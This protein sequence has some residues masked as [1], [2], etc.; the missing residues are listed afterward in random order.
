MIYDDNE[1]TYN[2]AADWSSSN[3]ETL[4]AA[5]DWLGDKYV[6]HP[7]RYIKKGS[8]KQPAVHKIDVAKTFARVRKQLLE[9]V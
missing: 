1:L 2:S 3:E 6:L 5:K 4:T 9:A 7:S 8:Y